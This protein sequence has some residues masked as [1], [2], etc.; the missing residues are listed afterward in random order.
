MTRFAAI[1]FVALLLTTSVALGQDREEVKN[2]GSPEPIVSPVLASISKDGSTIHTSQKID[3]NC[4]YYRWWDED[5][6][7]A[8]ADPVFTCT[9]MSA[10]L[11]VEFGDVDFY[12]RDAFNAE[13][14]VVQFGPGSLDVLKGYDQSWEEMSWDVKDRLQANTA[15]E[16]E[17]AVNVD[18]VHTSDHWA[19]YLCSARLE[20]TWSCPIP[21]PVIEEEI[22]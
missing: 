19:V 8:F 22:R 12:G 13:L 11:S 14:D 9:L 1:P 6:V 15:S 16:I 18:A 21:P 7:T 4:N 3:L 5:V 2:L 10:T 20:T 17:F